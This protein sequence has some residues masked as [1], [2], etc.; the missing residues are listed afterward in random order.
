[1]VYQV[2][3]KPMCPCI[4]HGDGKTTCA[5]CG[6]AWAANGSRGTGDNNYAHINNTGEQ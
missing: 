2:K 1:M 5:R 4:Y 3:H 6:H